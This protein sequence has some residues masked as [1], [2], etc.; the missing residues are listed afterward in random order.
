MLE[1][2]IEDAELELYELRKAGFD[3]QAIQVQTEDD[4]RHALH[5]FEPDVVISDFSLPGFGG[6]PAL[7]I[8]REKH[9][10]LPFIFVSGTI[11]EERAIESFRRGVTDYVLKTNLV[12]L[13]P[14]VRRALQEAHERKTRRKA[15]RDLQENEEKF[16]AII[17]TTQEW[18]WE[19]DQQGRCTFNSPFVQTMLGYHSD[20]FIGTDRFSHLHLE[21]KTSMQALLQTLNTEKRG[22]NNLVL[23]WHHKDGSYRSLESNAIPLLDSEGNVVGYRGTDHD[24]TER[25]RQQE[26]IARLSRINA[27]SSSINAAIVRVHSR[28]ELFND[29]CR[30]AVEQGEFKM[31]WIGL[32][33][34]ITL[35]IN[36]A[37][38]VGCG[39]DHTGTNGMRPKNLPDDHGTAERA[40]RHKSP[41]VA[42]NLENDPHLVFKKTSQPQ[43]YRS[44]IALPL[45]VEEKVVAVMMLYAPQSDFFDDQELKLLN[46][47]AADISFALD[48][49]EKEERL[50]YLSYYD[51]LTGLPNRTLFCDRV[52]QLIHAAGLEKSKVALLIIDIERFRNIN[53]TLGRHAGDELLKVVA[54]RLETLRPDGTGPAR[55]SG[56]CFAVAFPCAKEESAIAHMVEEKVLGAFL[57]PLMVANVELRTPAKFGIALFPNDGLDGDALIMNA[58]AALKKAKDCGDKYSFY[59]PQMHSRIAERLTLENKLR[60]ALEEKQFVL[61]YQPKI[62]LKTSRVTGLETLIRWQ[63]PEHGLV[64]PDTFIPLLE[65]TGLIV[66]VGRWV[67]EK[68]AADH[69]GLLEKGLAPPRI[70]VNVSALQLRQKGFVDEI[71]HAI[72]KVDSDECDLDIEVTESLIMDDLEGSIEKLKQIRRM[73]VSVAL[74]DF[75]TG[76]SS[77][78]YLV[79]L[80][81]DCLKIDRTFIVNM[82]NHADSVAIV[83]AVISLAHSLNLKVIAEGVET[84][85]QANL[86][87]LLKCDEIQGYFFSHPV[88]VNQ[89]ET[90]LQEVRAN[91]ILH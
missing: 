77:L 21:D 6:M 91:K 72:E 79:R 65:E 87:E 30:I 37:A 57:Q 66:E 48:H 11:G 5:Q 45:L 3:F 44:L 34:L 54:R 26:K 18:I 13:G 73:G 46:N 16:R 32:V 53:E 31:A 76:F 43:A 49:I 88:P 50:N 71:A 86:L 68:A 90:M 14:I 40:G 29:V 24:V 28:Q 64:A 60:R 74:D 39:E 1:D 59:T 9:P 67:M 47:L 81:V 4:F 58:E 2:V 62:D 10:D 78:G 25:I 41:I 56:D 69:R 33:D 12:R 63:S 84:L 82:A 80:P 22:W 36:P 61:H 23:R 15:E 52:N 42:N 70:A 38:W 20:E 17:E 83:S 8:T 51:A 35:K 55:I 89:I 7:A 19:T 75:G 27:V 85:E